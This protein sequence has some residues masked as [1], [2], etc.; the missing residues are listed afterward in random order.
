MGSLLIVTGPPGAGKSTI[1]KLVAEQ[2]DPSVVVAGD[3]FFEFLA[4]GAIAPWLPESHAQNAVVTEASAAAAGCFARG[5]F[6]TVYDGI[7]GP[8]FL[9][10]FLAM[11]G[12]E[13]VNYVMLLPRVAT[14]VERVRTRP[15]HGFRDEDAARQMHAEFAK[16]VPDVESRHVLEQLPTSPPDVAALIIDGLAAGRFTLAPRT[17]VPP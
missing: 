9:D 11:V 6:M 14:C 12:V 17:S 8:W 16:S 7:L 5:N 1:S 15:N 3:A 10:T 2:F 4:R 13:I